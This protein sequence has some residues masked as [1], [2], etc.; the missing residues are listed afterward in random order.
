MP[1]SESFQAC[2]LACN[3]SP[4]DGRDSGT[5][6][7][8]I[9][10][11][12]RVPVQP[13]GAAR[14]R[15]LLQ[16]RC[17]VYAQV[18]QPRTQQRR[19]REQIIGQRQTR[20]RVPTQLVRQVRPRPILQPHGSLG[21][22]LVAQ[23]EEHVQHLGRRHPKCP[24]VSVQQVVE[25]RPGRRVVDGI[26]PHGTFTPDGVLTEFKD[27]APVCTEPIRKRRHQRALTRSRRGAGD[28]DQMRRDASGRT[29]IGRLGGH[30]SPRL[31][32]RHGGYHRHGSEGTTVSG[33]APLYKD[34]HHEAG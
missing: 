7:R 17:R 26:G 25:H 6:C 32:P 14:P 33:P 16:R 20:R 12:P 1:R 2:R 24:L 34:E 22:H 23:L 4:S 10:G 5:I 27:A 13:R 28:G 31:A 3:P 9:N 21:D 29:H 30:G 15:R 19:S 11:Q 8:G 18:E